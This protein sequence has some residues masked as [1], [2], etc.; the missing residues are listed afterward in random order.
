VLNPYEKF[1]GS[2]NAEEVLSATAAKL[3]SLFNQLGPEGVEKSP[4]PGKW[5]AREIFSHL[6]DCEITFAFRLRQALAEN[7]HVIQ[8]FDQEK[9]AVTYAAYDATSALAAFSAVRRW[10]LALIRNTK[11]E[12]RAK[13]V[14]HPE[15]GNMTF[16][17][18]VETMAGHDVNHLLQLEALAG[19]G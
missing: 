2:R 16:Q 4:A 18:I 9:W 6:A 15:R 5:N 12:D 14:T 13:E 17:T 10:N 1:L 7:N 19:K 3:A 8:P 11:P